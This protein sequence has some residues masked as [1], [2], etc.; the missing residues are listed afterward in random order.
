MVQ[1]HVPR[2]LKSINCQINIR[3]QMQTVIITKTVNI[4][5]FPYYIGS[6]LLRKEMLFIR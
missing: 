3:H 2:V 6:W 4:K 5:T 1:T